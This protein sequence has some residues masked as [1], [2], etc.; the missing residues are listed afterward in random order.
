MELYFVRGRLLSLASL[1]SLASS[2]WP[3][4]F[5]SLPSFIVEEIGEKMN[6]NDG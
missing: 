4:L 3:L 6:E 2:P 1:V 5:S